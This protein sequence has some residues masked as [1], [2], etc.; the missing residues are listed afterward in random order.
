MKK[1]GLE[2]IDFDFQEALVARVI[3]GCN[4]KITNCDRL[5]NWIEFPF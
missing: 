3:I 5:H 1:T 2:V 4:R